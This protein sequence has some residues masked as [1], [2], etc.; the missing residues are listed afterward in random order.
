VWR[1][2]VFDKSIRQGSGKIPILVTHN[3]M[4]PPVGVFAGVDPDAKAFVFR[5][6]ISNTQ[7]GDDALTLIEDGALSGVSVG[8]SI[9]NNR[10]FRGGVERVEARVNEISLTPFAQMNDGVILAVRATIT[11]PDL[12]EPA[13]DS[14]TNGDEVETPALDEAR[15]YLESLER[16]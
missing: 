12:D 2:G 16:P 10:A 7:G 15:K 6:R 14:E 5:A 3:R 1:A 13:V 4:S 11:D 8:A 9:F